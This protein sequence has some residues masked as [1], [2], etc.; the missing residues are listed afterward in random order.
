[1]Q[2]RNSFK[3]ILITI[4]SILL[5]AGFVFVSFAQPA[6]FPQESNW[7]LI[8]TDVDN[9]GATDDW[10]DIAN[11]SSFCDGSYLF[12]RQVMYGEPAL[13]GDP[14]SVG[15]NVCTEVVRYKAFIN[16]LPTDGE[17]FGDYLIFIEDRTD[18][19][20]G[21]YELYF[22]NDTDNDDDFEDDMDENVGGSQKYNSSSANF[23]I[24]TPGLV[25]DKFGYRLNGA[26]NNS[27]DFYVKLSAIGLNCSNISLLFATDQDEANPIDQQPDTDTTPENETFLSVPF[28]GDGAVNQQSEECDDGNLNNSDA[29]HNNCTNNVCG[30]GIIYT[31]VEQCEFN[32]DCNDFNPF[33]VDTCSQCVCSNVDPVVCGDGNVDA[34]EQCDDGNTA[35]GDGCDNLCQIEPF[36]GDGN[37]DQGEQ[38]DGNDL[39]GETCQSLGY[40]PG[41]LSCNASCWFDFS[42]CRMFADDLKD[43][44]VAKAQSTYNFGLGRYMMVNDKLNA[45][46]RSYLGFDLRN[47]SLASVAN[48]QL[49]IYVYQ[50]GNA[51]VGSIIEA[52][53]CANVDFNELTI[54]WNNQPSNWNSNGALLTGNCVLAETYTATNRVNHGLPETKHIWNLTNEVNDALSTD[55]RFTIVIKHD[56]EN[57]GVNTH[58]VQ[59]LTKEYPE[60]AYRPKLELS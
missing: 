52:W 40:I 60:S 47:T 32:A 26:P 23:I 14:C 33:T 1:M 59:Y 7:V 30:D 56:K 17:T 21:E 15:E 57:F 11:V 34:G 6:S 2:I 54:T 41:V 35:N 20:D 4:A 46:D 5:S 37:L 44:K 13:P 3:I 29:C 51:V 36:C 48:A 19:I 45:I 24:E 27:V 28:C 22:V 49:R 8:G 39:D 42:E 12:L 25:N 38:C 53:Y 16:A 10:R 18:P 9:N 55:K 43:S 58:Y 31:G 50:T